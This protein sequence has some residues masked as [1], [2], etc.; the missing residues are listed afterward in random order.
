MS[1]VTYT[2][3][4]KLELI[5]RGLMAPEELGLASA[6]EAQALELEQKGPPPQRF[7]DYITF[8]A[9]EVPMELKAKWAQAELKIIPDNVN[10]WRNDWIEKHKNEHTIQ[11]RIRCGNALGVL[12]RTVTEPLRGMILLMREA[13]DKI[14]EGYNQQLKEDNERSIQDS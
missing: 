12:Q 6:E 13:A 3:Q 7:Q 4:E 8:E 14:E 5:A 2:P 10:Q 1:E 9:S 11:A